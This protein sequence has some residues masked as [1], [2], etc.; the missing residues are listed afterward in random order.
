MKAK[1]ERVSEVIEEIANEF[2]DEHSIIF[3][4]H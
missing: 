1:K 4:A 2:L 3:N